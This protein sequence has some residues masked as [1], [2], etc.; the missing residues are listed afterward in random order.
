MNV[1]SRCVK[2]RDY[3][4]L[5]ENNIELAIRFQIIQVVNDFEERKNVIITAVRAVITF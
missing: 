5:C 3:I 4:F 2:P 1:V